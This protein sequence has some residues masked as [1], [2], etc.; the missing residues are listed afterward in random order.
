MYPDLSDGSKNRTPLPKPTVE[1]VGNDVQ[2]G[3]FT[4]EQVRGMTQN[5][6]YAG[7][8]P[9]P[10]LVDDATWVGAN[11]NIL[12]EDGP[13]Q[14]LVNL[15]HILRETFSRVGDDDWGTRTQDS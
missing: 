9:F 5:P 10:S 4:A 15:L 1:W 13:R 2:P 7:V 12:K 14:Y 6:I 3:Q 11:I 8:P